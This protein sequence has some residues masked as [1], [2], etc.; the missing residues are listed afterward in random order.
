[1]PR[2]PI[3]LALALTC[4]WIAHAASLQGQATVIDADTIE[5]HGQR[6]RLHGIDAPEGRQLCQADGAQYRCG[7]QA[8]LA[9]ADHIGR[10]AIACVERA[11][12][13]YGRIVA[14]CTVAGADV[15]AWLV[16]QGWA[17]AYRRDSRDYIDEE[18][19][20]PASCRGMWRGS[21]VP[22]WE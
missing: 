13:R 21:F 8:A 11:I 12:D 7:Q 19:E 14:V 1:M 15:G 2:W 22:P 20:A 9:L 17:M 5:I 16:S 18:A 6:I 3:V 10:R 4:A